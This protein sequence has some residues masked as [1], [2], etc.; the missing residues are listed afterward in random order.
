MIGLGLLW[1]QKTWDGFLAGLDTPQGV[2]RD[3]RDF[4]PK[5]SINHEGS[6]FRGD[7]YG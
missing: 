2:N 6:Y 4:Q 1:D 3:K 5:M 7:N